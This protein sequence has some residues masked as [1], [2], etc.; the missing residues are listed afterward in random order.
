[1]ECPIW[2]IHNIGWVIV[3]QK[4]IIQSFCIPFPHMEYH[5]IAQNRIPYQ[6]YLDIV[7]VHSHV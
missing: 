7:L 1:M 4:V 6:G 3:G 2:N 5:F